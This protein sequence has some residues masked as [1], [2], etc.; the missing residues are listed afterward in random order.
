VEPWFRILIGSILARLSGV[1][2][3]QVDEV[4][5]TPGVVSERYAED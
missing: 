1:E 4:T 2:V 3:V 5:R